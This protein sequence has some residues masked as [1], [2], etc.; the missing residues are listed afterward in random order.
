MQFYLWLAPLK[1]WGFC[2]VYLQLHLYPA[3]FTPVLFY[4]W[5]H[6]SCGFL[7]SLSYFFLCFH[8]WLAPFT[9]VRFYAWHRFESALLFMAGTIY[10]LG[11]CSVNL[12]LHL[13]LAPFELAFLFMPGTIVT[14]VIPSE[15]GS[16][17]AFDA[18]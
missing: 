13:C 1:L 5:H 9:Q 11:F 8:L 14:V 6:C 10:T 2:S 16:K 4:G 7:V 17:C 18:R 3:P 15:T 12:Q